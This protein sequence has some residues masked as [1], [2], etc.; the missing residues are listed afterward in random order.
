[1]QGGIKPVCLPAGQTSRLQPLDKSVFG[2]LKK[3]YSDHVREIAANSPDPVSF[4]FLDK[5]HKL[6]RFPHKKIDH[7]CPQLT[8]SSFP[9]H[10][11]EICRMPN[12]SKNLQSGFQKTGI[13][14]FSPA[15]IQSTVFQIPEAASVPFSADA[16][17]GT[18]RKI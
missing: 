15:I 2:S 1:L 13:F 8:R 17:N 10:L 16:K 9:H 3:I 14:P 7:F 11:A 4:V 5:S 12:F 6:F 18:F